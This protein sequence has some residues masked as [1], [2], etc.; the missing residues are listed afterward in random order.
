MAATDLYIVET[1]TTG[2]RLQDRDLYAWDGS[3][4]AG[5]YGSELYLWN[6]VGWD[7]VWEWW[8]PSPPAGSAVNLTQ[9]FLMGG[10]VIANWTNASTAYTHQIEWEIND[11]QW[12]YTYAVAGAQVSNLSSTALANLD[13]VEARMR[14]YEST[15]YGAWSSWSTAL[16]Y[17]ST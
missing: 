11:V 1:L 5:G 15:Y 7:K 10:D 14:Y 12:G 2:I 9:E 8:T 13:Q 17:I 4:W 3:T 6:G 16:T